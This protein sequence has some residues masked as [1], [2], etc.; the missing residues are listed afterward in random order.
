MVG[1]HGL[2]VGHV[3]IAQFTFI[4]GFDL[5]KV[6]VDFRFYIFT[7]K[8]L[9]PNYVSLTLSTACSRRFLRFVP[10]ASGVA[11]F[12]N[13]RTICTRIPLLLSA[14][15]YEFILS[16]KA[17]CESSPCTQNWLCFLYL[18]Y[19]PCRMISPFVSEHFTCLLIQDKAMIREEVY[20][21][22]EEKH[23]GHQNSASLQGHKHFTK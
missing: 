4:S 18:K 9:Q 3:A 5:K 11:V 17:T 2:D 20:F 1:D 23:G 16:A 22:M 6:L 14:S 8:W 13:C 10:G 7:V 21:K 15:L 19:D 12:N